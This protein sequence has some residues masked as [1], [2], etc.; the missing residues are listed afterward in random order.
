VFLGGA[1]EW[2]RRL[3]DPINDLVV[4]LDR[5]QANDLV[6]EARSLVLQGS[7]EIHKLAD[8]VFMHF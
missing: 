4:S 1:L 8:G 2:L 3:L 7:V 5:H 6:L